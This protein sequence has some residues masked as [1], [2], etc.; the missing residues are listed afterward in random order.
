MVLRWRI[1]VGLLAAGTVLATRSDGNGES[2][3][4]DVKPVISKP[5][6]GSIR[7]TIDRPGEVKSLALVSRAGGRTWKPKSFNRKTGSFEFANLPGDRRYDLCIRTTDGRDIEGI[8]LDFVDA[9]LIRMAAKR[10]EMLN[11]PEEKTHTFTNADA[12]SLL[13]FVRDLEEFLDIQ[14]VIYLHGQGRRATMLVEQMRTRPFH[15]SGGNMIWRIDLWYFRRTG[16][17]WERVANVERNLRRLRGPKSRWKEIHIEYWP[18]LSVYLDVQGKAADLKVKLPAKPNDC[19]RGRAADSAPEPDVSP[20]V[21]GI[22][23]KGI[24]ATTQ[25]VRIPSTQPTSQPAE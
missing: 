16:G 5:A 4:P 12:E 3:L 21:L 1:L 2:Q 18:E 10:R 24:A 8:D 19:T 17:G 23:S 14:R 11:L 6:N 20:I 9:R 7:G 25:P 13:E 22:G 15:A